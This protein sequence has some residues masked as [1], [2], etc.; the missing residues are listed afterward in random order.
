MTNSIFSRSA[1]VDANGIKMYYELHGN[2]GSHIVL[3]HG[4]GSTIYTTFGRILPLLAE[5]YRV[6]AVEL[7]GHGHSSD[8][9]APESFEQ[10]A[11]D[12]A[13]LLHHLHIARADI[14]GF[15]NGGNTAMQIAIRHPGIVNKL[16]LASTFYQREGLPTGMLESMK[17]ATL[18]DMPEVLRNAFLEINPDRE[19]LAAMF[20]KDRE[21][22]VHFEDWSDEMLRSVT[23]PALIIDGD[24]DVISPEHAVK[25][26]RLMPN[27]RLF[28]L[29][30]AHG[31]YIGAAESPAAGSCAITA[32]LA[33]IND[34]LAS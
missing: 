29:P 33:V 4:G 5:N 13:V 2:E 9:D 10:D 23:A 30:A 34:F 1:Y 12:V 11:D 32:T 21:R 18:N 17:Q 20:N 14:F 24:K 25:M 26:S 3:I 8:R 27:S 28:I 22:M 6:V 15:S 31:S 7:Q 16:V 19:R